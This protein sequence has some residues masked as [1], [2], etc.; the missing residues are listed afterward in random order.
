MVAHRSDTLQI[1]YAAIVKKLVSNKTVKSIVDM[2]RSKQASYEWMEECLLNLVDKDVLIKAKRAA[3]RL[4]ILA[5]Q[6]HAQMAKNAYE[7]CKV[8]YS[9]QRNVLYTCNHISTCC[10]CVLAACPICVDKAREAAGEV[11][12]LEEAEEIDDESS[13]ED[14]VEDSVE[15]D[16]IEVSV[17]EDH[18]EEEE[19]TIAARIKRRRNTN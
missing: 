12:E 14:Q 6:R 11:E 10:H 15:E 9:R 16:H 18:S 7:A 1:T 4:Q 2:F 8:C 5:H 3:P 17:E 13:Q 19:E